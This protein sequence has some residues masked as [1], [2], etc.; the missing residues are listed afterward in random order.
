MKQMPAVFE[1]Q[2]MQEMWRRMEVGGVRGRW[3]AVEVEV[4]EEHAAGVV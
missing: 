3:R 1:M 2:G 4:E